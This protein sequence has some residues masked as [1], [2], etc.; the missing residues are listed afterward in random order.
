MKTAIAQQPVSVL[1]EADRSVFQQYS[2]GIMNSS[3]CGTNLDHA[4]AVVG[5]GSSSGV[6]YWIMRNSWGSWWGDQGYMKIQQVEGKGICGVQQS[7]YT[8]TTN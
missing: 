5:Y 2:G 4:T 6:D 8:V 3:L 1:V 7:T